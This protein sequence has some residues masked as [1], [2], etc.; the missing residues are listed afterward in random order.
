MRLRGHDALHLVV[1]HILVGNLRSPLS[2][3][4]RMN[5]VPMLARVEKCDGT[6]QF[7][8]LFSVWHLVDG[9]LRFQLQ[10]EYLLMYLYI[11][12]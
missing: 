6:L 9:K 3:T 4:I 11:T 10:F 12:N 1:I 7:P 5:L 2:A 8:I